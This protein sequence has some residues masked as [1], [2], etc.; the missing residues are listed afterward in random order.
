MNATANAIAPKTSVSATWTGKDGKTYR[1]FQYWQTE[2][3]SQSFIQVHESHGWV[4]LY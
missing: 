3:W 2:G 1:S 4:T